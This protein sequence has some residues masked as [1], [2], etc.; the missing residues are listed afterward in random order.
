MNELLTAYSQYCVTWIFVYHA[1][2]EYCISKGKIQTKGE[3]RFG[4]KLYT[5]D[6]NCKVKLTR[7]YTDDKSTELGQVTNLLCEFFFSNVI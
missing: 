7:K 6:I 4:N 5:R 3:Q 2:Y 1:K